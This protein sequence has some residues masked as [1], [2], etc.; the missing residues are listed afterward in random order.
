MIG[1]SV[2]SPIRKS[3]PY[4]GIILQLWEIGEILQM[5]DKRRSLDPAGELTLHS[6]HKEKRELHQI[7]LKA[8]ANG[9]LQHA[10][11]SRA[12]LSGINLSGMNLSGM[13]L[14]EMNFSEADLRE[15]DLSGANL[16][17]AHFFRADI[18][19]ADL[20]KAFLVDAD[21]TD[22]ILKNANLRDADLG[23]ARFIRS[24]L[25]NAVVEN[26]YIEYIHVD[27][28]QGYPQP[29]TRLRLD[30]EG[31]KVWE[32]NLTKNFFCRPDSKNTEFWER[33]GIKKAAE[34][35]LEFASNESVE[36]LYQSFLHGLNDYRV[37]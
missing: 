26:T 22:A 21:F 2:I 28:L 4:A 7:L 27:E 19:D 13:N 18:A 32:G 1:A 20:Q 25:K 16:Y 10:D 31:F 9:K 15:A 17:K 8:L 30:R 37:G 11:L 12:A 35:K 6:I 34:P 29:P 14:S 5:V 3:Q 24:D 23:R 36:Y 33:Y